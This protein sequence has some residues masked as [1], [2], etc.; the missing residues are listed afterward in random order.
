MSSKEYK[1]TALRTTDKQC[2]MMFPSKTKLFG[3]L[4]MEKMEAEGEAVSDISKTLPEGYDPSLVAPGSHKR[5]AFKKKTT[6]LTPEQL[7]KESV[8]NN[9]SL[10]DGNGA[11][12]IGREEGGLEAGEYAILV[13]TGEN[14]FAM[15]PVDKWY[16]FQNK[17]HYQT[18]SLEE[19]EQKPEIEEYGFRQMDDEIEGERNVE[20]DAEDIAKPHRD[21]EEID[22]DEVFSDDD[23]K[24]GEGP[25]ME[26]DE[27]VINKITLKLIKQKAF[28]KRD[29]SEEVEENEELSLTGKDLRRIVR[30]LEKNQDYESDDEKDP[31]ADEDDIDTSSLPST[32]SGTATPMSSRMFSGF[33]SGIS[34][35]EER[36]KPELLSKSTTSSQSSNK[37]KDMIRPLPKLAPAPSS[38]PISIDVLRAE[39]INVLKTNNLTAKELINMF[40]RKIKDNT[41]DFQSVVK[42]VA[43]MDKTTRIL[44]LKAEFK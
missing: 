23:E 21:D 27:Q 24:I 1:L 22:F 3:P 37:E 14:S 36:R 33:S 30:R 6:V 35:V 9:L 38:Q 25:E 16:R 17:I 8:Q 10:Q 5:R 7:K 13:K 34:S 4:S 41:K 26:E 20:E 40:K 19:A 12:F 18:L 28:K 31:Y 15:I 29:T 44:K 2:I 11:S 32:T 43:E 39:V 42:Q